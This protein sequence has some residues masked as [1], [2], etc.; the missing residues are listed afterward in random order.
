MIGGKAYWEQEVGTPLS[1][2]Q[3]IWIALA[4]PLAGFLLGA[5]VWV[6][7]GVFDAPMPAFALDPLQVYQYVIYFTIYWSI[8]NLLPIYPLDGGQVL[9]YALNQ[10][11]RWNARLLT[12]VFTLALGG[13][14]IFLAIRAGEWWITILLAF[15]LYNNYRL[16]QSSRDQQLNKKVE[17][18]V[19]QLEGGELKQAVEGAK[20]VLAEAKSEA[21]R[22]WAIS[23][24]GRLYAQQEKWLEA[25]ELSRN[26][27][28]MGRNR[29]G[30]Q[31]PGLITYRRT[32]CGP[33]LCP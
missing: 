3:H 28:A 32:G 27:P 8:L 10:H 21:Y 18:V 17:L 2:G 31:N 20:T 26:H 15:I 14:L 29:S 6:Y 1:N 19:K 13:A 7:G 9:F 30:G 22:S 23:L 12:A 5:I 4:G 24:L 25:V 11:P 16:L 33:G